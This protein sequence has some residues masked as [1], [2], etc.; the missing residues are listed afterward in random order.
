MDDDAAL[1]ERVQRGDPTAYDELVR[2][3]M[4]RAFAVAFR[5]MGHRED[6]EDLVQDAFLT[7]LDRIDS[8]DVRRGSGSFGPWLYRILVRRG[9]NSRKTRSLRHTEA[10]PEDA[11]ARTLAPDGELDRA[12]TRERLQSALAALP[13]RHRLVIELFE[14]DGYTTAEIAEMLELSAGTVR[15][16]VHEARR[17]LRPALAPLI[18]GH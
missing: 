10:L 15:W 11:A 5:V 17:Q 3:Y 13:E 7:A 2:R 14:L 12:E 9:I 16:Y 6:A 4:K 8:F 1:V 18:E